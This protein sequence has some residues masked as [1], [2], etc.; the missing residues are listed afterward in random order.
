MPF[1]AAT[2][3]FG[4]A[5]TALALSSDLRGGRR[6]TAIALGILS[7]TAGVVAGVAEAVGQIW[8][9]AIAASSLALIAGLLLL[10]RRTSSPP[11]HTFAWWIGVSILPVVVVGGL[12]SAINER[13]LEVSILTLGLMWLRLGAILLTKGRRA[14]ST[15]PRLGRLSESN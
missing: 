7:V 9:P 10:G 3:F 4:V 14:G 5:L 6:K 11:S 1:E 2:L 15:E 12:L 13:L 8:G